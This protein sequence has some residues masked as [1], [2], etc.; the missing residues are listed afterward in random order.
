M[1]S[2]AH[3]L[4]AAAMVLCCLLITVELAAAPSGAPL[5]KP[6]PLVMIRSLTANGDPISLRPGEAV[7]LPPTPKTVVFGFGAG[8]TNSSRAPLRVRYKL[9]GLDDSWREVSSEMRLS[10]RFRDANLDPVGEK[11]F[12][13]LG[14]TEGWTGA[15][16][17]STFVHRRNIVTVP[18]G[19]RGFWVSISSAGPPESV[20]I[21]AI[22]NLVIARLGTNDQPQEVLL[23][24]GAEAKG[25]R[26][27]ADWVPSDWIRNGLRISMAKVLEFG[28]HPGS[29]ALAVVDNDP[30]AHAEWTTRRE[31]SPEV[32]PG[33][34]LLFEWDEAT[35]IGM[36]SS[37][38]VTY[39]DLPSG[40]YHFRIN[41][42]TIQGVPGEAEA[43]LAFEVP[44]PL[45]KTPWFW[46]LT[47][48]LLVV[49]AGGIHRYVTLQAM[50]RELIR[51]ETQHAL[52]KER[53]RI[54]R[55]IHDDL[56]ARVTQISLVSGLAQGD[57]SLPDKPRADF[58]AIS[59]L[60]RELVFALSETVWAVTPQNDNLD[61]FGNYVCQTVGRLCTD[62][63]LPHRLRVAELPREVPI[64]SQLRHNLIL[65]VKESVNNVIKHARASELLVS[66]EWD[67]ALIT[68]TVQ[69][70]GCG[71][72]NV[73]PATGNGLANMQRRMESVGGTCDFRSERGHGTTVIFRAGARKND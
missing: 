60:A 31:S 5:S 33:E 25:E 17:T 36:G 59:R 55:D 30:T 12:L 73:A 34:R 66:V 15:L 35:S 3:R 4:R 63:Q 53:L 43:S 14:Q 48:L 52:E 29:K 71:M 65:S 21:L 9:E 16:E 38:T 27:G 37:K 24:W 51:L 22:T 18:Q 64:S 8:N 62:A 61:A 49:A 54:A 67:G 45:W 58:A 7:R 6:E 57:S 28:D 46:G 20:G 44:L 10:L 41:E 69:D 56:G 70:N 26:A 50:R 2:I 32:I 39:N 47:G 40:L 13:C 11:V 19:S 1:T 68:I 42:L 72:E 23:R